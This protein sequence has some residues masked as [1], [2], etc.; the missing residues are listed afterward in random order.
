VAFSREAVLEL[1]KEKSV[2]EFDPVLLKAFTDMIGAYPVGSLVALN[3]GEIGIVFEA[4]AHSAFSLRPKVKIIA[5]KR[6]KKKDGPVVDLTEVDP[7]TRDFR[8][9]ILKAI[10]PEKYGI[11][12]ADYFIARLT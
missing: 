3:S 9:A 2:V 12:V 7:K 11:S 6:G 8:R 10:D 5:D 1:M 4:N